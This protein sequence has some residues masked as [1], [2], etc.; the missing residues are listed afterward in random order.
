VK[1]RDKASG[2]ELTVYGIYWFEGGTT[3][4]CCFPVDTHGLSGY[5]QEEVDIID[6]VIEGEFVFRVTANK[7]NGFFHKHVLA[8]NL[9]DALFDHNEAAYQKLTALLGK[10]P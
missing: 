5:R 6:P 3:T 9:L 7:M 1:I 4:F 8:D 2:G 10:A